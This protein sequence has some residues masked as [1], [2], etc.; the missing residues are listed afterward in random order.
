MSHM[1][2]LA[3]F[4][5]SKADSK[6]ATQVNASKKRGIKKKGRLK[7][8]ANQRRF[9][10]IWVLYVMSLIWSCLQSDTTGCN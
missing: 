3:I 8:Y 2:I 10:W 9:Y 4:R 5:F 7:S 1:L 6:H